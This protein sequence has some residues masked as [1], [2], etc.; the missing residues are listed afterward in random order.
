MVFYYL[1]QETKLQEKT[2]SR[3]S[4]VLFNVEEKKKVD[5]LVILLNKSSPIQK[6]V[7]S[8]VAFVPR[9]VYIVLKHIRRNL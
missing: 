9:S 6:D 3:N 1:S 7:E 4:A 8:R 2:Q 5:F